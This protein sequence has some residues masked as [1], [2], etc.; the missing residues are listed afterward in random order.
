MES[1]DGA[2]GREQSTLRLRTTY[3]QWVERE[4]IPVVSGFHIQDLNTLAGRLTALVAA[5]GNQRRPA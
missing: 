4:G 5:S 3:D 2:R 1:L